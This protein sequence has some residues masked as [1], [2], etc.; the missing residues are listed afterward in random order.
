MEKDKNLLSLPVLPPYRD[1]GGDIITDA[2]LAELNEVK[3]TDELEAF[4]NRWR[5]LW[6][7]RHPADTAPLLP[8]EESL[9][10]LTFDRQAVLDFLG[11]RKDDSLDFEDPNVEV[12]CNLVLPFNML[13]AFRLS[14]HYGVGTDLGMVRCFLDPYT[15]LENELR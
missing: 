1:D 4:V 14:H 12:M 3:T 2:Y 10:N 8:A 13:T 7:L 15:E 6:L 5:N 11:R 9:V